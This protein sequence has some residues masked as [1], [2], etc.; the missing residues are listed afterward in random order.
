MDVIIKFLGVV[1]ILMGLVYLINP[2]VLRQLMMF[3][4]QG[5][6]LYVAGLLRFALAVIFLLGARE[7]D[8]TWLITAFG[9][10]FIISGLLIF[11]L[12]LERIK[13]ILEWYQHQ[14]LMIL[15]I[16]ALI[17]LVVGGVVV[18]AA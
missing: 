17:V 1:F 4:K 11:T 16:I 2:L 10:L 5:K 6:R 3:F 12:G 15:R 7:C 14:P 13:S 8:I 18:Y 9:I